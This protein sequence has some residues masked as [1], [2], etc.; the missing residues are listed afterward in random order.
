LAAAPY[1][2]LPNVFKPRE[3]ENLTDINIALTSAFRKLGFT[4]SAKKNV[5]RNHIEPSSA[6]STSPD[7]KMAARISSRTQIQRVHNL[8]SNEPL[9]A[10]VGGRSSDSGSFRQGDC[11]IGKELGQ[12]PQNK[13]GACS[14]A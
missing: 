7:Q 1:Y 2:S 9:H 11:D 14:D 13:E 12:I 4:E 5:C 8:G 10:S 3:V 6:A